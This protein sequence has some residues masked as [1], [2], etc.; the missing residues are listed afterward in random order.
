MSPQ[1]TLELI[2]KTELDDAPSAMCAFQ[3]RLL[4][5]LG[6][7]VRI[8]DLGKKKLLRKCEAKVRPPSSKMCLLFL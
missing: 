1:N 2:H 6:S 3:G 8:Y 7:V 4:I 5:G